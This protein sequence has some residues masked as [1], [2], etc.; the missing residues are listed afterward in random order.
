MPPRTHSR[1]RG[2]STTL[3]M[4]SMG[5]PETSHETPKFTGE[6]PGHGAN[7][8]YDEAR[9]LAA[10]QY[11]R[12]LAAGKRVLDAGCGEG[13]NTHRLTDVAAHVTGIDYS[14]EAIE[15]C[16]QNWRAANLKFEHVDLTR[17]QGF[18][19]TFDLVLNFQVLEHIPDDHAFLGALRSRLAPGGALL[20]TTP[21]RL[22][23]F[24][25]NPYHVREYTAAELRTLLEGV[26]ASVDMRGMR[27]NAKVVAFDEARRRS[28][29]R[30]LRLDPLGLRRMLPQGLIN[31]AFARLAAIVRSQAKSA[32]GADRITVDDFS[33][34]EGDLDNALDLV[35]VCSR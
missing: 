5:A 30:I 25:E 34:S 24:S 23:S 27:G 11:A 18:E 31:F 7:F 1:G 16:R 35:A 14:R 29:E 10:Y 20:L 9:H 33:V 15:F 19:E 28:V 32:A 12:T 8:D 6:R 21:N 17:P 26:F 3:A 4:D 22:M 13:Y 2:E